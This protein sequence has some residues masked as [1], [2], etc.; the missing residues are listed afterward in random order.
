MAQKKTSWLKVVSQK[1]VKWEQ[2]ENK[3]LYAEV[4]HDDDMLLWAI[5][6][7]HAVMTYLALSRHVCQLL[8]GLR[9]WSARSLEWITELCLEKNQNIKQSS[10]PCPTQSPCGQQ[11][12]VTPHTQTTEILLVS[13]LW[14]EIWEGDRNALGF[15]H[16]WAQNRSQC[17]DR[18]VQLVLIPYAH[19]YDCFRY[20]EELPLPRGVYL[21]RNVRHC[22]RFSPEC[23]RLKL[24]RNSENILGVACAM[25]CFLYST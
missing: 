7:C 13:L 20:F 21:N 1:R 2:E 10:A 14:T 11:W 8:H 19:A 23:S 25:L 17:I 5:S 4:W 24:P 9:V 6:R 12:K 18:S 16:G 3:S 22:V 15:G